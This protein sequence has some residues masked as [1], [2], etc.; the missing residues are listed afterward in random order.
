MQVSE[1]AA[2]GDENDLRRKQ[3]HHPHGSGC[4][5]DAVAKCLPVR[6][7]SDD[8]SLARSAWKVSPDRTVP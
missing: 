6:R 1:I 7:D 5:S 3:L 8:R 2:Y 4:R